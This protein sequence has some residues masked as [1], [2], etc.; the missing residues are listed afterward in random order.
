MATRQHLALFDLSYQGLASGNVDNDAF[1]VRLFADEQNPLIV[2]QSF[3]PNF[4]LYGERVGNL[5]VVC[6]SMFESE[7][8]LS[9]LKILARPMYSNPP[10]FGTRVVSSILNSPEL[11][12]EWLV[13]LKNVTDRIS[14]MRTQLVSALKER[15]SAHD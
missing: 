11:K 1:A 13:D 5:A 10:I 14:L 3:G 8:V 12:K 15:G 9:Q 4:G 7:K 2:T 6:D